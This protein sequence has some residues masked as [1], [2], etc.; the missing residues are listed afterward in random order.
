MQCQSILQ[1]L[2]ATNVMKAL[3]L[4][5]PLASAVNILFKWRDNRYRNQEQRQKFI[6]TTSTKKKEWLYLDFLHIKSE[7]FVMESLNTFVKD[8]FN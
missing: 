1:Q 8:N 6:W 2:E 5:A 3:F 7:L 4:T